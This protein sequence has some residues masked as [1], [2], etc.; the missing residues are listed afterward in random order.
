ME[1]HL[2]THLA[3]HIKY[4]N[5]LL[6]REKL[7]VICWR[8]LARQTYVLWDALVSVT[9]FRSCAEQI[10]TPLCLFDA[11]VLVSTNGQP[12]PPTGPPT[13][14]LSL[15]VSA[16]RVVWRGEQG[17]TEEFDEDDIESILVSLVDQV[18]PTPAPYSKFGIP[19]ADHDDC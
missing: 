4:G 3:W 2:S 16:A 7:E 8:N 10:L 19:P 14:S 17:S 1:N 5:Y 15:L 12:L 18:E 9:S 13:L 6:L 11:R